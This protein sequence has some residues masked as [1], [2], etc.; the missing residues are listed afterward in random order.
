MFFFPLLG[1]VY[2]NARGFPGK[3]SSPRSKASGYWDGGEEKSVGSTKQRFFWVT[4]HGCFRKNAG[5]YPH[6]IHFFWWGFSIIDF[7]SF[8]GVSL[9]LETSTWLKYFAPLK[10]NRLEHN[11]LEVLWKIIFLSF[12]GWFVGEPA[13][14]LCGGVPLDFGNFCPYPHRKRGSTLP[15]QSA[16][17]KVPGVFGDPPY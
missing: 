2:E 5:F 14:Y 6:I 16:S 9:F 1:H 11:S 13:V 3:V 8:W 7:N 17:G 4:H 12:H 15:T 10:I